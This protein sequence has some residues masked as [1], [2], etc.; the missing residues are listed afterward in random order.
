MGDEVRV[1]VIA[2]G[3]DRW[4]EKSGRSAPRREPVS[5]EVPRTRPSTA[6][7]DLFASEPDTDDG[8]GGDDEFDVRR[9]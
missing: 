6:A 4:E 1:T 8:E 9:S 5:G 3:F 7:S 2:A